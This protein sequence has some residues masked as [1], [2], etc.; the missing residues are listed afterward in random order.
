MKQLLV[1]AL[2]IAIAAASAS[3]AQG[4]VQR[5]KLF[6]DNGGSAQTLY[7]EDPA[8]KPLRL[9]HVQGVGWK[10]A[11]GRKS[12]LRNGDFLTVNAIDSTIRETE[13][14]AA[15]TEEF[16]A[17]FVD[18]PSGFAYVWNGDTGWKFIGRL[19]DGAP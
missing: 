9:I 19:S 8:G 18:G 10:Y 7:V 11:E 4:V 13:D 1:S 14:V 6:E 17:V 12:V 16:L 5:A 3:V 15:S 2:L